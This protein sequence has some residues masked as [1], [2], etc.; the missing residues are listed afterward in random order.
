M[1]KVNFAE[2]GRE[3]RTRTRAQLISAAKVFYS[4]R[5]WE[6]VTI[7]EI[8]KEAGV[9]KGTF[10]SYFNDLDDLL[11]AL[12]DEVAKTSRRCAAKAQDAEPAIN[13]CAQ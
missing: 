6:S 8:V 7:D 12:A 1:A 9:E 13:A 11:A 2:L 10:F 5:S 4:Q 3:E